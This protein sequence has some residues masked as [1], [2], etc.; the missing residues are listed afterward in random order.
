MTQIQGVILLAAG[1]SRRMGQPKQLLRLERE[2]LIN[3]MIR[4]VQESQYEHLMVVLGAHREKIEPYIPAGTDFCWN[5]KWDEGMS[6]SLAC[7]LKALLQKVPTIGRILIVLVDQ[8]FVDVSLLNSFY[9]QSNLNTTR[10]IAAEY[11]D[12]LGVPASFPYPFFSLLQNTQAQI[13]ARKLIKKYKKEV[14]KISFPKGSEDL[15][16]LSDWQDF[17]KKR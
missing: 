5:E 15:D 3:R 4:L 10:I 13:G 6:G 17:L 9:Y 14:V 11:D 12:V 8:P 16:T 7:G 1:A 2:T